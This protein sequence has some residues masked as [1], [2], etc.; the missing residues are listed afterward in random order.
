LNDYLTVF[1]EAH[2]KPAEFEQQ[3]H[4]TQGKEKAIC[5]CPTLWQNNE[6][7]FVLNFQM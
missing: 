2:A 1:C 3:M 4:N 7:G 6:L 5:L